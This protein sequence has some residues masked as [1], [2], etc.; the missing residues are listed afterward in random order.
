[1]ELLKAPEL[2]TTLTH[3]TLFSERYL[4]LLILIPLPFLM[5]RFIPFTVFFGFHLGLAALM[6]LGHFP[7][8]A[9]SFWVLMLPKPFWDFVSKLMPLRSIKIG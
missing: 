6:C 3:I 9:L 7:Y 2:L 8:V 1:M 4:S 5:H